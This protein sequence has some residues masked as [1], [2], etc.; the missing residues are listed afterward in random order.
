MKNTAV[1]NLI[2]R[3]AGVGMAVLALFAGGPVL[4]QSDFEAEFEKTPLFGE[5]DMLPGDSVTRWIKVENKGGNAESVVIGTANVADS[6]DVSKSFEFVVKKNAV[7]LYRGTLHDFLNAG[8]ITLETLGGQAA[9]RYDVTISFGL[10]VDEQELQDKRI[11]FDI[12]IGFA[13]G[14]KTSGSDNFSRG[15]SGQAV[16][17]ITNVR[18]VLIGAN[19]VSIGWDTNINATS[20]LI[21]SA[22]SESHNFNFNAAPLYGYAHAYPNPA[23]TGVFKQH[24]VLLPGLT[25]CT[26]YY[27]R[28][29]SAR[30]SGKP[31]VSVEYSFKTICLGVLGA[32][33]ERIEAGQAVPQ[34]V[35]G[36]SIIPRILGESVEAAETALGQDTPAGSSDGAAVSDQAEGGNIPPVKSGQTCTNSLPWWLFLI[37]AAFSGVN[38]GMNHLRIARTP[39]A[40]LRHRLIWTRNGWLIFTAIMALVS[41]WAYR[42][43]CVSWIWFVIATAVAAAMFASS[44]KNH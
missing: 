18:P 35:A 40:N 20:Q 7:E 24:L 16:F 11:G 9:V 22:E 19:E 3:V 30:V 8:E 12:T 44:Q 21:Y 31:S 34:P 39:E 38:A 29:L 25:Q 27:Y 13:G 15:G 6:D 2:M 32:A 37:L 36:N 33:S 28:V 4:A 41:V 26:T 14:R 42:S 1:N 17:T 43:P 5:L 23:G 10:D